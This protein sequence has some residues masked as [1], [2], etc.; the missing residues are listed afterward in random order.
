MNNNL[1]RKVL[2]T[3]FLEGFEEH[4]YVWVAWKIAVEYERYYLD[5]FNRNCTFKHLKDY[6]ESKLRESEEDDVVKFIDDCISKRNSYLL[7]T[8]ISSLITENRF[9]WFLVNRF[10]DEYKLRLN[11][12]SRTYKQIHNPYIFLLAILY[13]ELDKK[14]LFRSADQKFLI[15][16]TEFKKIKEERKNLNNYID[17]ELF[18]SWSKNYFNKNFEYTVFPKFYTDT[19]KSRQEYIYSY[20]DNLYIYDKE[21]YINDLNRL[22]KAWQQKEFRDKDSIKKSYH[23]PLR[24]E[25]KKK[26]TKLAEFKNISE[27]RILET[28]VEQAYKEEMCDE[29]GKALY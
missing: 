18:T 9:C 3:N 16:E 22:K 7:R 1:K 13:I 20:F 8:D 5:F 11:I 12:L 10:T 19:H 6:I 27:S 28:L 4:E 2:I 15:C 21:K 17:N 14:S 26:L 29:N 23:L 24:R 25:T